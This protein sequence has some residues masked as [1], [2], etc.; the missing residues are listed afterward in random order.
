MN[1]KS[2][3][4][5]AGWEEP[6]DDSPVTPPN[7]WVGGDVE[8]VSPGK[9]RRQ[10]RDTVLLEQVQSYTAVEYGSSFNQILIMEYARQ[11]ES[12]YPTG[13]VLPAVPIVQEQTDTQC[14]KV[15][16]D[17]MRRLNTHGP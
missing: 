10:W 16:R 6:F 13:P 8:E 12:F 4:G 9:H 15:A 17:L 2:F 14:A 5:N 7:G 3:L 11:D 1:V